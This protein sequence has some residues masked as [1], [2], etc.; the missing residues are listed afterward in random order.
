[1]SVDGGGGGGGGASNSIWNASPPAS[2][3]SSLT[4]MAALFAFLS[5]L[6]R[7]CS[8]LNREAMDMGDV[9]G[10]GVTALDG[11]V[12]DGDDDE[13]DVFVDR[14]AGR[15]DA[16]DDVAF[17]GT[18]AAS[19]RLS[20]QGLVTASVGLFHVSIFG[21]DDDVDDDERGEDRGGV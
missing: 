20:S 3:S 14:G 13:D 15:A 7:V 2:S 4:M 16:G 12:V 1:M 8:S 6:S 19:S 17:G 10:E 21:D 18:E 9:T 5:C 11:E